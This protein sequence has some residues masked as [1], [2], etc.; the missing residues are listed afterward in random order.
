M[1]EDRRVFVVLFR[2]IPV[3]DKALAGVIHSIH[4]RN[5]LNG[6]PSVAL[7]IWGTATGDFD[8]LCELAIS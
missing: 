3:V 2:N 1:E 8:T 6:L 4:K 5:L 7:I